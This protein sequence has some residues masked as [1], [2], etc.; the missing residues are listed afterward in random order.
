MLFFFI[1]LSFFTLI[2][3]IVDNENKIFYNKRMNRLNEIL[4]ETSFSLK[5]NSNATEFCIESVGCDDFHEVEEISFFRKQPFYTLHYVISGKGVLYFRGKTYKVQSGQYFVLPINENI[6]Y[7]PDKTDPWKYFWFD[8]KGTL[9]GDFFDELYTSSPVLSNVSENDSYLL[10]KNIFHEIA[11]SGS[12]KYY[13]AIACFYNVLNRLS[14]SEVKNQKATL[15][16]NAKNFIELNFRSPE[17]NIEALCKMT[18]I[19]HSYLCKIFKRETG[20]TAKA[21]LTSLRTQ[22]AIYLLQH[23]E[24][25]VKEIASSVGFADEI[26]FMKAF[27]KHHRKTPSEIRN[28]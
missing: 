16:E 3:I 27:K 23:S 24:L 13:A 25:S 8:F 22:E 19:S 4:Q 12:V 5:F 9:A 7:L 10:F 15:V 17:F 2:A 6:K 20:M 11:T 28:S 26:N 1:S 18:H 14:Q 21:Y